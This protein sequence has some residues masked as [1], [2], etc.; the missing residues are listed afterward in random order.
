MSEFLLFVLRTLQGQID[1]CLI[2]IRN[3]RNDILRLIIYRY[4]I[5]QVLIDIFLQ[6]YLYT[7]IPVDRCDGLYLYP[8]EILFSA[9][10]Y[11][12]TTPVIAYSGV[13]IEIV[14]LRDVMH[15]SGLADHTSPD[16]TYLDHSNPI[17]RR[18]SVDTNVIASSLLWR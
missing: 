2:I 4:D 11:Q 3:I 10:H 7:G 18:S 15:H 12:V 1:R 13:Y 14:V 9:L 6:P 17:L 8:D 16:G 5:Y